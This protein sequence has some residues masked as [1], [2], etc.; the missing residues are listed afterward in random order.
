MPTTEPNG[1]DA[2]VVNLDG[3]A[4]ALH[5]RYRHYGTPGDVAEP[6]LNACRQL[7]R[8][9]QI[10]WIPAALRV[11][12][13]VS[14]LA[15]D[16]ARAAIPNIVVND[17]LIGH[18]GI[19]ASRVLAWKSANRDALQ[20]IT[21]HALDRARLAFIVHAMADSLRRFAEQLT[22]RPTQTIRAARFALERAESVLV[23]AKEQLERADERYSDL[24]DSL[25]RAPLDPDTQIALQLARADCQRAQKTWEEAR[26]AV[27]QAMGQ[28]LTTMSARRRT[29]ATRPPKARSSR[30]PQS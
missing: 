24:A 25:P 21:E 16:Q 7:A 20:A 11:A 15:Q 2:P 10:H 3:L 12:G 8:A 30:S 17:Y 5:A 28:L 4:A 13:Q 19:D 23:V 14:D 22:M 27:E 29:R 1:D 6:A 18:Y 9:G 26:A